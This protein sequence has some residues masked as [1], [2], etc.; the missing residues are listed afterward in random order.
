MT[1]IALLFWLLVMHA[2]CDFPLQ[3]NYLSAAKRAG[4]AAMHW[5][6]ALTW[7]SLIHAG[8][9]AL[10]TGSIAIGI[11]ELVSHWSIDFTKTRGRITDNFDQFLH[12]ACKLA[13]MVIA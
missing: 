2:L 9:V 1:A 10:V 11:L 13:W 3:G 4:A 7:H 12:I 5:S 6:Y 8:A